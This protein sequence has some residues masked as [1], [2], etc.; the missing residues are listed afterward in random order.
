MSAAATTTTRLTE[1]E[2]TKQ[3]AATTK[4]AEHTRRA[5]N[6]LR[7]RAAIRERDR[8]RYD[9]A[10]QREIARAV[11]MALLPED[12]VRRRRHIAR[13]ARYANQIQ[14]F[15]QAAETW[16]L[17]LSREESNLRALEKRVETIEAMR[18]GY[19][20][21]LSSQA[22]SPLRVSVQPL[23]GDL[24]EVVTD[25]AL[26][27]AGWADQFAVQ[28]GY[29]PS[30][31]MRMV[32][33]LA[34]SEVEK[35]K[36]VDKAEEA[37][38]EQDMVFWSPEQRHHGRSVGDL[39]GEK[40]P[41][42][43]LFIHSAEDPERDEKVSTLRRVLRALHRDDSVSEE[44]LYPMYA[45]WCLT[46]DV[47]A[48]R[49]RYQR[50]V[51]FVEAHPEEFRLLS[52][53][54]QAEQARR[55][56][57]EAFRAFRTW[58]S[59]GPRRAHPPHHKQMTLGWIDAIFQLRGR[60]RVVFDRNRMCRFLGVLTVEELFAAGVLVENIAPTFKGRRFLADWERYCREAEEADARMV[61][62]EAS[63]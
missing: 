63:S 19:L 28:H 29:H 21:P 7:H 24:L 36:G 27:V 38:E 53:E 3:L 37:K 55:V 13:L 45:N 8:A 62:V 10:Y 12:H 54:E 59:G 20:I 1:Y 17:T 50:M 34:P 61:M 18:G 40:E 42:L 9:R 15:A 39:L 46:A 5:T 41:L 48:L 16:R 35:D 2:I 58:A 57:M 6:V 60:D 30:A 31:T 33:L 11:K 51:A 49:N 56:D 47:S 22:S 23:S 26:P 32:F 43:H 4:Q 25:R 52:E 44:T 14:Y